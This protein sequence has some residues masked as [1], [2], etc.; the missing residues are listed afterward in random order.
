MNYGG[1]QH[2]LQ[3]KHQCMMAW[4]VGAGN[5]RLLTVFKVKVF[6]LVFND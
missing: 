2:I 5:D 4:V 6:L 1:L 3:L